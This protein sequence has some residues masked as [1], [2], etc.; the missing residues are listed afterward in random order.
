M[1]QLGF[2]AEG[3]ERTGTYEPLP[4]GS[5]PVM[6]VASVMK[7]PKGAFG[8]EDKSKP[9]YLELSIDVIDGEYKGR[10]L[11]DRLHLN[12]PSDMTRKIAKGTLASICDALGMGGVQDSAELHDKPMI[13]KVAIKPASGQYGP[14]NEIKGYKSMVLA[15]APAQ[16]TATPGVKKPWE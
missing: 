2:N 14:S 16:P 1:A 13:A 5:Y 4:V 11:T 9:A 10:K 8:E 6:V 12:N 7:H 15:P 3:V